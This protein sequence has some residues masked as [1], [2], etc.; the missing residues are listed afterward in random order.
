MDK[1]V[2]A[3]DELAFPRFDHAGPLYHSVPASATFDWFDAD[4]LRT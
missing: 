2:A 1:S 3:T 4:A